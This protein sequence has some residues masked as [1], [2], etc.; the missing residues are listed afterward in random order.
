MKKKEIVKKIGL[1]SLLCGIILGIIGCGET[2]KE[3]EMEELVI[4]TDE[5]YKDTVEAL[6][7]DWQK[8]KNGLEV[9][10]ISIP[11]DAAL[12]ETKITELRTEIMSGAGPDVFIMGSNINTT[13]SDTSVLFPNP[14]KTMHSNLFLPLDDYIDNTQYMN[15]DNW[16]QK[17][18]SAGKTEEGQM[19]LPIAYTY[20]AYA[21]Y[22]ADLE[23]F[24]SVPASWEELVQCSVPIVGKCVSNGALLWLSQTFGELADY[25][26]ETLAFSEGELQKRMEEALAWHLK[27][28]GSEEDSNKMIASTQVKNVFW[29]QVSR[30]P[31]EAKT[32]IA[33][34]N[35][36]NGVTAYVTLY[37]AINRNTEN[38]DQSFALLDF[39]FSDEVMTG[40]GFATEDPDIK[41]GNG[42]NFSYANGILT[43]VVAAQQSLRNQSTQG[44]YEEIESRIN[45]VRYYSELDNTIS[46]MYSDCFMDELSSSSTEDA[47]K[48][49]VKQ[50][51]NNMRMQLAE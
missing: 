5:V 10:I 38:P 32:I 45:R 24:S 12:A 31:E 42:N 41:Y 7:E 19:I 29:E 30:A 22:T 37:A 18:M 50:A 4:C 20:C 16:N 27:S 11:Q 39:M 25:E 44:L 47:K 43:N 40:A 49:I 9:E 28:E 51:Y 8:M 21:F 14:E 35:D 2:K 6:A 1:I 23:N 36:Q 3:T 26:N 15:P 33:V 34:P 46:K 13:D 48:E 17:I